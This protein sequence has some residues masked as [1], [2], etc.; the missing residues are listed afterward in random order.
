MPVVFRSQLAS[1]TYMFAPHNRVPLC[2]SFVNSQNYIIAGGIAASDG[3]DAQFWVLS[4]ELGPVRAP[5]SVTSRLTSHQLFTCNWIRSAA[6]AAA[7]SSATRHCDSMQIS[8]P[9]GHFGRII[10]LWNEGERRLSP[11]S[12]CFVN[13]GRDG[14][15]LLRR[16]I[17]MDATAH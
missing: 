1:S 2:V 7:H 3:D 17:S 14:L 10:C 11:D 5:L 12:L 8:R 6:V 13:E 15:A 16:H 4:I 9:G